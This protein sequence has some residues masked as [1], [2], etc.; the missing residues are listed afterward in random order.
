M[1]AQRALLDE[2]MGAEDMSPPLPEADKDGGV[3]VTESS[4]LIA[5]AASD[6]FSS[7][8]VVRQLNQ[9]QVY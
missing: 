6:G 1:D 9:F 3:I 7:I 8:S 2:L 4:T 5:E